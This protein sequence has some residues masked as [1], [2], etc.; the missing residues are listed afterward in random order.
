MWRRVS[1]GSRVEEIGKAEKVDLLMGKHRST[2]R[3]QP[4]PLAT[5]SATLID[6]NLLQ[7]PNS[8]SSQQDLRSLERT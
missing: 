6:S 3:H 4:A 7:P 2:V 1:I 8:P 5:P